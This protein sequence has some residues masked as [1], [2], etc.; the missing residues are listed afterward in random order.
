MNR[1]CVLEREPGKGRREG[2]RER[3]GGGR[4]HTHRACIPRSECGHQRMTFWRKLSP[5][6]PSTELRSAD[7]HLV[8]HFHDPWTAFEGPSKAQC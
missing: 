2:R 1:L 7:L 8:S 3:R 5:E 4:K 6:D